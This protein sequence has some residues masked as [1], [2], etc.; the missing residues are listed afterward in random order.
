M[1]YDRYQLYYLWDSMQ[2]VNDIIY[3][4]YIFRLPLTYWNFINICLMDSIVL[5]ESTF[6]WQYIM[7]PFVTNNSFNLRV[8]DSAKKKV[9]NPNIE[10]SASF[11]RRKLLS[12]SERHL[13]KC[14]GFMPVNSASSALAEQKQKAVIQQRN[15]PIMSATSSVSTIYPN[16]VTDMGYYRHRRAPK[17]AFYSDVGSVRSE[18]GYKRAPSSS[19]V[20]KRPSRSVSSSAVTRISSIGTAR[21]RNEKSS[22]SRSRA[23]TSRSIS[24]SAI[25]EHADPGKLIQ[26]RES[27]SVSESGNSL[28]NKSANSLPQAS[29]VV[30]ERVIVVTPSVKVTRTSPTPTSSI[31]HTPEPIVDAR[32]R[33]S[34]AG[35]TNAS[36]L[37]HIANS[38]KPI[39]PFNLRKKSSVSRKSSQVSEFPIS[40]TRS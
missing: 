23:S 2:Q 19:Y 29:V 17:S 31:T 37:A 4:Y 11:R 6:I 40:K 24:Y 39:A 5:N 34:N 36:E 1:S 14:R 27:L 21:S 3:L 10:N 20:R 35:S 32:R 26:R 9:Q 15:P 18:S 30:Q 33:V 38:I 25:S 13:Y 16:H 7:Y 28:R 22:R 12:N 8:S